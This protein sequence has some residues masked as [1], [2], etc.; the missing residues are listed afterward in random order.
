MLK[1]K[2]VVT[3]TFKKNNETTGLAGRFAYLR[4]V[5]VFT[6]CFVNISNAPIIKKQLYRSTCLLIVFGIALLSEY[7]D[8]ANIIVPKG[9]LDFRGLI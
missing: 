4:L 6:C 3:F 7:F 8:N 1:R 2:W 5:L 9:L